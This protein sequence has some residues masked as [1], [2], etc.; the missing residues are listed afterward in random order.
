MSNQTARSTSIGLTGATFLLL[1]GLRLTDHIDWAWYWIAAP[2]WMPLGA[3][4]GI[5]LVVMIGAALVY[6][7]AA[8]IEALQARRRRKARLRAVEQRMRRL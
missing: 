5:A 1:L 7:V 4:L 3:V 6:A 8:P 2:L